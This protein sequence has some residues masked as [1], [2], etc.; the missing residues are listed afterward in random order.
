MLDVAAAEV[1]PD[2]LASPT[3]MKPEAAVP[4]KAP[5]S[6]DKPA[7]DPRSLILRLQ[8]S[9]PTFREFKPVALR[10]DKAIME[11]FPEL[12]R[13]VVRTAMRIHTAS[14]RYLKSME[15]AT[16]RFDLEGAEAGEVTEE[17]RAHAALTL[18]ERFAEIARR[19]REKQQA[20]ANRLREEE[21]ERRKAEKLEQLM[22]K[23]SSR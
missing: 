12:D 4:P 9:S 15:K 8:E 7:M 17:H 20:E 13:K 19:K 11:R 3:E 5:V 18:K 10:I 16:H 6:E 14:T 2:I 22:S 1:F 21:A 23:F